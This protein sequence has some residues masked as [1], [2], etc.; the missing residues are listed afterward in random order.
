MS[1]MGYSNKVLNLF[2][3]TGYSNSISIAMVE[4]WVNLLRLRDIS[5]VKSCNL[6][7][8][9]NICRSAY[10]PVRSYFSYLQIIEM[11]QTLMWILVFLS[12]TPFEKLCFKLK[13]FFYY[14]LITNRHLKLLPWGHYYPLGSSHFMWCL[15]TS[16]QV[17]FKSIFLSFP[18]PFRSISF[19]ILYRHIII[20]KHGT[21]QWH[22]FEMAIQKCIEKLSFRV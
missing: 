12:L 3:C 4:P 17:P 21:V 8:F 2:V 6:V 14:L 16:C 9:V 15:C 13:T 11:P 22:L 18:F 5:E 7:C 1:R 20:L 19:Q 10:I